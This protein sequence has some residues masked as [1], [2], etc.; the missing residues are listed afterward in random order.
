[1]K[2]T[3]MY[4]RHENRM[5]KEEMEEQFNKEAKQGWRSAADAARITDETTGSKDRKH[6]SGG[7]SVAV[8]S[9]SIHWQRRRGVYVDSRKRKKNCPNMADCLR[10]CSVL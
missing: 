4:L 3:K 6:T 10:V 7:L 5:R 2:F 8:D 9:R 1:M